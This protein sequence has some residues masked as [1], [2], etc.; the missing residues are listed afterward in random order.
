MIAC[1]LGQDSYKWTSLLPADGGVLTVA[2]LQDDRRSQQP[3]AKRKPA[4]VSRMSHTTAPPA[5]RPSGLAASGRNAS[6][7]RLN[8]IAVQTIGAPIPAL[9][10]SFVDHL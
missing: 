9:K 6:L 7:V 10:L 5:A 3:M 8:Q 1:I 2:G 4:P